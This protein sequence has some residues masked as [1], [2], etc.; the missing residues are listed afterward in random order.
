[1][2]LKW[3]NPRKICEGTKLVV[4]APLPKDQAE[5]QEIWSLWKDHKEQIR[6]DGFKPNRFRD[7]PWKVVYFCDVTNDSFEET[8]NG[9]ELWHVDFNKK[10]TKWQRVITKLREQAVQ[11][12]E[13]LMEAGYEEPEESTGTETSPNEDLDQEIAAAEKKLAEL[14]LRKNQLPSETEEPTQ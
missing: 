12:E 2:G 5:A 4:E 1:M 6:T 8:I 11:I 13:E 7:G 14:R 3:S 9:E 10:C